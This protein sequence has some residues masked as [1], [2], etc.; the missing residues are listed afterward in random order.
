MERLLGYT[1]I[2]DGF[3]Q[4]HLFQIFAKVL[5]ISL[6]ARKLLNEW[7]LLGIVKLLLRQQ[8]SIHTMAEMRSGDPPPTSRSRA[9]VA[10]T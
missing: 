5:L 2:I 4:V 6:W 8:Q 7:V 1:G 10:Q 3:R 9:N